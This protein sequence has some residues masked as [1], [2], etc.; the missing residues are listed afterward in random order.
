MDEIFE[1]NYFIEED[2]C[3]ASEHRKNATL[4][5][6]NKYSLSISQKAKQGLLYDPEIP[7]SKN[8]KTYILI[9]T[10]IYV[11]NSFCHDGQNQNNASIHHLMNR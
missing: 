8:M 10:Y 7:F 9:N 2:R 3:M 1:Q 6:I 11:Q 4:L 5:M